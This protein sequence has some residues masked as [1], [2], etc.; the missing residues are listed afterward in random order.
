MGFVPDLAP[1]DRDPR[2]GLDWSVA[3]LGVTNIDNLTG[4]ES[5]AIF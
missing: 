1:I 3:N 5:V 4:R 2:V